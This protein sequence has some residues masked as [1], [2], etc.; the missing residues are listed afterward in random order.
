[1]NI[2]ELSITTL[3]EY[4]EM[5]EE[6][7]SKE[8]GMVSGELSG[9]LNSIALG[10]KIIANLVATAGFKGLHGYTDR[11]NIHN[12]QKKIL[13][14]HSDQV[15]VSV[16]AKS[17]H[18]GSLVSEERD[19]EFLFTPRLEEYGKY[20]VAIDPLDGS[21][22]IGTNIPVGTI[23]SIYK[24]DEAVRTQPPT[25]EDFLQ[26]G[27]R[28]VA[29][30]YAI[31]GSQT[32]FVYSCGNGLVDFTLDPTIG[33]FVLVNPKLEIPSSGKILSVNESNC[34]YWNESI[35]RFISDTK[36]KEVDGQ[37]RPTGYTCRYV[38]T[39]VSDVDRTIRRG[40]I[41]V[42]PP[43]SKHPA[44]RLR[45]LYECLPL[46]YLMEQA[47]GMATDGTKNRLVLRL[48]TSIHEKSGFVGGEKAE[49]ER[50]LRYIE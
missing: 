24:R 19:N 11:T 13:D 12:D 48:P 40:G 9:L 15:F 18:F 30:G 7:A 1:M 36:V 33:E 23:F 45:L 47:G 5:S 49:V 14:E 20:V 25:S 43:S 50:Y 41:F 46:A 16:L 26:D 34:I 37:K 28:I 42:Y 6:A 38:G 10:V 4:V 22:N 17:G 21:S 32:S 29:A 8:H 35:N 31:Y 2:P 39:M 44:G 27:T 3:G